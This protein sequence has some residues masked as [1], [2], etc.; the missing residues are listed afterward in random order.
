LAEWLRR[1][2]AT[3]VRT[4]ADMSSEGTS[5]YLV[6]YLT[7]LGREHL[8][9]VLDVLY[10]YV[11]DLQHQGVDAKLYSTISDINRLEWDWSAPNGPGDTV[12]DFAERMTRLLPGHLLTGD[13]LVLRKSPD[14]VGHVLSNLRRIT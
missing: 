7:D 6:V 9:L 3:S 10:A 2:P 1:R 5:L 11:A 12:E 14:L 4:L 13:S 8:G